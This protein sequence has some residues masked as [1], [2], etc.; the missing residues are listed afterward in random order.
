MMVFHVLKYNFV[1]NQEEI[2]LGHFTG[3]RIIRHTF[4]S[5]NE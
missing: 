3:V 5:N 1:S 2:N 4:P